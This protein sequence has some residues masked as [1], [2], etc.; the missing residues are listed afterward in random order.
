MSKEY[1]EREVALKNIKETI[2][3]A[4][5]FANDIRIAAMNA[6]SSA[7]T[8]DV[9]EVRHGK[10]KVLNKTDEMYNGE[11]FICSEC[12]IVLDDI[13]CVLYDEDF[14]ELRTFDFDCNYCPNCGAKMDKE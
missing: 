6:V 3:G 13:S 14:E 1:I 11:Y 5:E 8:T 10:N 7:P 2:I 9:Q 12:G 4:S